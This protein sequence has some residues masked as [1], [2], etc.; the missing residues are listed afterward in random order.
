VFDQRLQVRGH[1]TGET[2]AIATGIGS[3]GGGRGDEQGSQTE[4]AVDEFHGGPFFLW[5]GF[6][7]GGTVKQSAGRFN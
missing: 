3:Q 4:A 6:L 5:E 2:L 7:R 1:H